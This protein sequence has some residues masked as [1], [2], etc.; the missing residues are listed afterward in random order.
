MLAS[1]GPDWI[2]SYRWEHGPIVL[3]PIAAR[4]RWERQFTKA[5][6]DIL[7]AVMRPAAPL[8]LPEGEALIFPNGRHTT[9]RS[10]G[11][12]AGMLVRRKGY[13]HQDLIGELFAALDPS[14]FESWRPIGSCVIDGPRVLTDAVAHGVAEHEGAPLEQALAEPRCREWVEVDLEPGAYLL[15]ASLTTLALRSLEVKVEAIRFIRDRRDAPALAPV[16]SSIGGP[17]SASDLPKA[18]TEA[19]CSPEST[20]G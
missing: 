1:M 8:E 2:G 20:G 7:A 12:S 14:I 10:V 15:H 9:W 6:G 11:G 3:A 5:D 18:P 4:E 17:G 13:L 19:P 16:A